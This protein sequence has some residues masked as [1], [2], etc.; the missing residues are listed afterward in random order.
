MTFTAWKHIVFIPGPSWGH[1]R[2]GLKTSLRIVEKF[3]HLFISLFVYRTELPKAVKYLSAQP[4]IYSR[5]IKVITATNE[6]TPPSIDVVNPIEMLT[7]MEQSFGLW[8]TNELQQP[9]A[10][11]FEGRP[12]DPPSLIIEDMFN[13]GISLARKDV[14]YKNL[15]SSGALRSTIMALPILAEPLELQ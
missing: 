11:Q 2:P 4:S 5:R 12:V 10:I 7:D 8:I 9:N 3:P 14:L 6:K 15:K 13:G 1:L